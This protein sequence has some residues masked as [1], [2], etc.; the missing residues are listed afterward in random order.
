MG[1]QTHL[2][3]LPE[4]RLTS[5]GRPPKV[6]SAPTRLGFIYANG[7][8]IAG[9]QNLQKARDLI[10]GAAECGYGP[11]I[12][13]LKQLDSHFVTAGLPS[14]AAIYTALSASGCSFCGK[15]PLMEYRIIQDCPCHTARY[16][17]GTSCQ[18]KQWK[19]HKVEHFRVTIFFN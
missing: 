6:T 5:S 4:R 7:H 10:V 3:A 11:S 19:L 17:A 14:T 8:G 9:G 2:R 16:C 1:V 13:A 18:R 15:E 12:T